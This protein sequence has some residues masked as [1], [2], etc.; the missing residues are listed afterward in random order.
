MIK[1]LSEVSG[2][3]EYTEHSVTSAGDIISNKT[4]TTLKGRDT[5]GGHMQVLLCR[6]GT[7]KPVYISRVV[8]RAFV[9]GYKEGLVI[10]HIDEDL[11]NA[12]ATNLK[13]VK[14]KEIK[15]PKPVRQLAPDGT[16]IKVWDSIIGV[17]EVEGLSR[18]G[19]MRA[20]TGKQD[21]Y[22]GFK[23]E[24]VEDDLSWL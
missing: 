1:N 17:E 7:A 4:N 19:V 16:P 15:A 23:W 6:G 10:N 8:G 22:K 12:A 20:A 13:W 18:Y 21:L 24:Y 14:H 11:S 2:F 9:K 3:E 5:N